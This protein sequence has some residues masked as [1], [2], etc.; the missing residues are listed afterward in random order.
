MCLYFTM[1]VARHVHV[2]C[3]IVA[4]YDCNFNKD[5]WDGEHFIKEVMPKACLR[6]S[7]ISLEKYEG[8]QTWHYTLFLQTTH[9]Q[10]EWATSKLKLE[11]HRKDLSLACGLGKPSPGLP[12]SKKW[13]ADGTWEPR[14][15][16]VSFCLPQQRTAPPSVKQQKLSSVVCG[17]ANGGEA[18]QDLLFDERD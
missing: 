11:R 14:P 2:Y 16:C 1:I 6:A 5:I 17:T 4:L 9:S 15:E 18:D 13:W 3:E 10:K 8:R 7:Q 12:L